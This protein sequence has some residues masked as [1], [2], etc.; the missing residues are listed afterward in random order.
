[1]SKSNS[2]T[3]T[4]N[5]KKCMDE[6]ISACDEADQDGAQDVVIDTLLDYLII[7]S[8]RTKLMEKLREKKMIPK[9]T[10]EFDCA[11]L[12]DESGIKIWQWR[13][14][15]QCLILFM[16]IPQV[17]VAETRLRAL[18]VDHGEI[19]H[20]TYYTTYSNPTNLIKVKEEV[21]DWTK[22]PVYEFVQTLQGMLNGHNIDPSYIDFIH[23]IHGGD[24]G[25]NKF[26]FVSKLLVVST[27]ERWT[28]IQSGG[29]W[30]GR[31]GTQKR[32]PSHTQ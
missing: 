27:C 10:D 14:I 18:G 12:L 30:A 11:A 1:M 3:V 9:V 21:R 2:G 29:I 8:K 7:K 19:K 5:I 6:L 22:D 16:D 17:G 28:F 4:P 24:H 13:K 25:K 31:C 20:G 32:S 23:I 26:Q 15:Q